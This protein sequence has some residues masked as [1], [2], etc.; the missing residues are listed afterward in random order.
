M[1]AGCD[2]LNELIERIAKDERLAS[3]LEGVNR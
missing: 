3:M 2:N 1:F